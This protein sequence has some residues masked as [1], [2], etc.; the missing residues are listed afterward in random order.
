MID[1]LEEEAAGGWPPRKTI[2]QMLPQLIGVHFLPV[3]L[4]TT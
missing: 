2:C 4:L 1:Q 3:T